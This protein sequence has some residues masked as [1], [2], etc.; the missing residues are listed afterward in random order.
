M[1]NSST[2]MAKKSRNFAAYAVASQFAF[3]V[4]APLLVFIV[5]GYY[6]TQ[7][8]GWDDWAMGV[9]VVL[10]IVFMLSGGISQ[11]CKIIRMYGKEDKSVPKSFSSTEDNDYF[12]NYR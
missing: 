10:G 9:C 11:L 7:M 4:L 2:D 1:S 8:F 12:D 3:S 5:G 6:A